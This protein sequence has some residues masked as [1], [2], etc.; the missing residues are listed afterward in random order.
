M[1]VVAAQCGAIS[2]QTWAHSSLV[3]NIAVLVV[4]LALALLFNGDLST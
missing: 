3:Q 2:Q 1:V 4:F